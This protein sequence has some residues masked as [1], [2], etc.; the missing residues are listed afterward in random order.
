MSF[1]HVLTNGKTQYKHVNKFHIYITRK[2]MSREGDDQ[3]LTEL[4]FKQVQVSNFSLSSLCTSLSKM[5]A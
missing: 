4:S 5:S 1:R 2:A 3:Q